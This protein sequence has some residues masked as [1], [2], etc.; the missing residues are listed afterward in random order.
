MALANMKEK[1]FI[2]KVEAYDPQQIEAGIRA[3]AQALGVS[4]PD[5][6]NA[7]L[8]ADCPWAH[9]RFAP[10]PHT[11]TALIEGVARALSG[12]SLTLAA[13][14][15]PE[16]PTRYSFNQAGYTLVAHKVGARLV[17][18]DEAGTR[19]IDLSPHA[20]VDKQARLPLPWHQATFRVSLPKLRGSTLV[21]FAGA[22]RHLQSLLPQ[23]TQVKDCHRLPEKM[24][25]LLPAVSPHLIIVDAIQALHNGGELSGEPIDLGL[26]VIGTHPLAVDV[27]CATALG[28]ESGQVDFLR[29]AVTRGLGPTSLEEIE[30]LG[31]LSIE[32]IGSR[33]QKVRLADP[34]PAHYPLP[35]Q[36]KIIRSEKA[37]QAGVSGSLAD[38]LFLLERAGVNLKSA[39][40]ATIVI[41]DVGQIPPPKSDTATLIFMDDTSRGEYS[42]YS[43]IIR[44]PGRNIPMSQLLDNVPYAMKVINLRAE[45]GAGYMMAKLMTNLSRITAKITGGRS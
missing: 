26:L 1:V 27:V 25:D 34:D 20:K 44:L 9:V 3:A 33:A 31:D 14:S 21:S 38:V 12:S 29:E 35:K 43:R 18:F 37:R 16:F 41:G 2:S 39:T 6:G 28:L 10:H 4:L 15:A 23:E 36:V 32:E 8:H 17:A 11:H 40:E 19:P 24:V 45:L 30:L 13:N 42:G 7:L 5:Q 22:V